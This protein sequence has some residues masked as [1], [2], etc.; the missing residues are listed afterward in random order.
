M[1]AE[2]NAPK[3]RGRTGTGAIPDQEKGAR[4]VHEW[5][6]DAE[7]EDEQRAVV[8]LILKAYEEARNPSEPE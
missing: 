6:Q 4:L 3:P 2:P 1:A 8:T 5:A 7:T